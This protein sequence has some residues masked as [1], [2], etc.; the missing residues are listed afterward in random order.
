MRKSAQL[1]I[2]ERLSSI[3]FGIWRTKTDIPLI[4]VR[5]DRHTVYINF[6]RSCTRHIRASG[7]PI[8]RAH[9]CSLYQFIL[10]VG[11]KYAKIDMP[12]E[13]F[14]QHVLDI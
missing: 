6:H 7:W 2:F 1:N 13:L 10:N 14:L 3:S 12:F 11:H 9:I 4:R 5:E 8:F